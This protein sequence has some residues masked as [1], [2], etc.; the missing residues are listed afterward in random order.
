MS[1]KYFNC[2]HVWNIRTCTASYMLTDLHCISVRYRLQLVWENVCLSEQG[3]LSLSET[4]P[5]A[6]SFLFGLPAWLCL[7]EAANTT[8]ESCQFPILNITTLQLDSEHST[9]TATSDDSTFCN[10]HLRKTSKEHSTTATEFIDLKLIRV[11]KLT[12]VK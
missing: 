4:F 11:A 1:I 9:V 8:R 12:K 6:C 5:T 10:K 3:K 7:V 2:F